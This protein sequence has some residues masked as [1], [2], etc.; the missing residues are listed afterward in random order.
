MHVHGAIAIMSLS[1]SFH[2][3]TDGT[4][5]S[6]MHSSD[7][8]NYDRGYEWWLMMEA[9]KVTSSPKLSR[10]EINVMMIHLQRNPGIK[11]YGLSWAY[12]AWVSDHLIYCTVRKM[13]YAWAR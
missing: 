1:I 13:I 5:S 3:Y 7:D 8:L 2:L 12:P 6:H 4:E 10:H 9:K 11:L